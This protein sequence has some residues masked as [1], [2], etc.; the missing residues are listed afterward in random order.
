MKPIKIVI[1]FAIISC[2]AFSTETV[3]NSQNTSKTEAADETSGLMLFGLINSVFFFEAGVGAPI[4]SLVKQLDFVCALN[5]HS[6]VLHY[7][8]WKQLPQW[9]W[10]RQLA[11]TT[12]RGTLWAL[13]KK[14][15]STQLRIG[16]VTQ[17]VTPTNQFML[18][19]LLAA[20]T[21]LWLG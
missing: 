10:S 12:V 16:P 7:F 20:V 4:E 2:S 5:L 6:G 3:K 15:A 14:G 18:H 11:L 21:G 9:S 13:S 17:Q 1:L 19:F 8:G